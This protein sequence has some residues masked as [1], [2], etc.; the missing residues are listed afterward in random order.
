MCI[1]TLDTTYM[2]YYI[3]TCVYCQSL[4]LPIL[5]EKRRL[6]YYFYTVLHIHSMHALSPPRRTFLLPLCSLLD[7]LLQTVRMRLRLDNISVQKTVAFMLYID[8]KL[9]TLQSIDGRDS[10]LN[11]KHKT[12][13]AMQGNTLD[14]RNCK[15]ISDIR[16]RVIIKINVVFSIILTLSRISRLYKYSE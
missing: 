2:N 3:N 16:I 13:L 11:V 8:E 5:K 12:S 7:W 4:Y 9:Y 1:V 15:Y 10:V 6:L 14:E